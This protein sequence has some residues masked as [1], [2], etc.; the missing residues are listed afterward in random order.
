GRRRKSPARLR[1]HLESSAREHLNPAH[2]LSH[3][4]DRLECRAVDAQRHHEAKDGIDIGNSYDTPSSGRRPSNRGQH[5]PAT[6]AEA[7]TD[8]T[9]ALCSAAENHLVAIDQIGAGFAVRQIER[10]AAPR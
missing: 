3:I 6:L 7:D 1:R 4:A 10:L 9:V 5:D 8:S 2:A